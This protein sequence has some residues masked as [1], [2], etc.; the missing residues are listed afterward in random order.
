MRFEVKTELDKKDFLAFYR[1]NQKAHARFAYILGRVFSVAAVVLL[2]VLTGVIA[3]YRLWDDMEVIRPFGL[4]ALVLIAW[5]LVNHFLVSQMYK[6]NSSVLKGD[7]RFGDDEVQA[8]MNHMS[9]QYGY[10]AFCELWHSQGVYYLY[11]DK[12]HAFILPERC[13]TQGDPAA[14]GRFIAE[15]TGIEVKEI[16]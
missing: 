8:D 12:G 13:F 9:G 3:V 2:I 7:Y 16:K 6:A 5:P 10:S 14:F 1:L 4:F 15:K 11:I